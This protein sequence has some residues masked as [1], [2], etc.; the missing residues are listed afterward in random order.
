MEH[1]LSLK[2][3]S[4]KEL[5]AL[6]LSTEGCTLI[7]DSP[8]D[9]YWGI[10]S[11]KRGKNKLGILLDKVRDDLFSN[12][13]SGSLNFSTHHLPSMALS[14]KTIEFLKT[15][16]RYTYYQDILRSLSN[17]GP[18]NTHGL[19]ALQATAPTPTPHHPP[20]GLLPSK[21]IPTTT[22]RGGLLPT[23]RPLK[24]AAL[25][26]SRKPDTDSVV[27]IQQE[28]QEVR[29]LLPN[30]RYQTPKPTPQ[31]GFGGAL[32]NA[33]Y[34]FFTQN[35]RVA[36]E[37]TRSQNLSLFT[38]TEQNARHLVQYFNQQKLPGVY[39]GSDN[40]PNGIEGSYVPAGYPFRI[41]VDGSNVERMLEHLKFQQAF[42]NKFIAHYHVK[43]T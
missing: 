30:P 42:I 26:P 15:E 37:G 36:V 17:N 34:N 38:K 21:N 20:E 6:L 27:P 12:R 18:I 25:L 23:I 11:D 7:E 13:I 3:T 4:H 43:K 39:Y 28:E 29:T 40:G 24:S 8:I 31:D 19:T 22:Q 35:I 33:F 9:S 1:A 14:P 16:K 10:G 5:L 32:S 41:S 2:F